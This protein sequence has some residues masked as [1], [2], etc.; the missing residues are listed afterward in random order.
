[1]DREGERE[2]EEEKGSGGGNRLPC[3]ALLHFHHRRGERSRSLRFF[4]ALIAFRGLAILVE[5]DL[6]VRFLSIDAKFVFILF[7]FQLDL[8]V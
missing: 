7:R 8:N 4:V 1:M 3:F 5:S 2:R 6:A